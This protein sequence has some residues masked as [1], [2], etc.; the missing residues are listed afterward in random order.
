MTGD[1]AS[2]LY[3]LGS[4]KALPPVPGSVVKQNTQP[5]LFLDRLSLICA[6]K[7]FTVP[8]A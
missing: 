8:P 2:E 5:P 3:R 6:F 4:K 7:I 1:I